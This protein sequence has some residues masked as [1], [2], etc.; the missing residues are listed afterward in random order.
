MR[1][2]S[3][4]YKWCKLDVT[5]IVHQGVPIKMIGVITDIDQLK[6]KNIALQSAIMY[7][8]FTGLYNKQSAAH[9]IKKR[10]KEYPQQNHA[11]IVL[12]IDNFKHVND[13]YGHIMGDEMI[14]KL[15]E[16]LKITFHQDDI[17][18]R[19]GGD[20]FILFVQNI[21]N[22]QYLIERINDLLFCHNDKM[23]CSNS[24]GIALYL[25]DGKS[26]EELLADADEALYQAKQTKQCYCFYHTIN[27]NQ[28]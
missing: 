24:L 4:E 10:L 7:D 11:L 17:V 26:F 13:T 19:F 2:G 8:G 23:T 28:E 5:P 1:A 15:S 21:E 16:K 22:E 14:L 18:G 27:V 9:F 3:S 6:R 12:D 20:E 25:Q